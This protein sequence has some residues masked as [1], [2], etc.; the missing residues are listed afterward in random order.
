VA[1]VFLLFAA[2]LVRIFTSEAEV[3]RQ[4]VGCLRFISYGYLFYAYGMVMVQAFNGAGDTTT[5][6]IINVFCYWLWEIP[7]AWVLAS[8]CGMGPNGVYLAI[9]IA[10]ST[11][12]VAGILMFRRGKW[13]QATI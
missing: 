12:T 6:T 5:P 10:E 8:P 13:K 9:A 1:V 2:P 11:L 3:V 7:L 4:G